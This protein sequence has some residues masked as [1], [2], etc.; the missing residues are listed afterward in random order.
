VPGEHGASGAGGWSPA[1]PASKG[2]LRSLAL[3]RAR[4]RDVHDRAAASRAIQATLIS[5]TWWRQADLLLCYLALPTEVQ[6]AGLLD[7]A[8]ARGLAA[9][10]PRVSGSSMR[11]HAVAAG[12]RDFAGDA[13]GV[14]APRPGAPVIEP[15]AGRSVLVVVPGL[16]FDAWGYRIGRGGGYYDRFL[17][18]LRTSAVTVGL[19]FDDALVDR[20]PRDPWDVPVDIVV[21][22]ARGAMDCRGARQG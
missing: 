17:G 10:A 15:G 16:A 13:L 20:V 6:T 2:E 11:F 14:R 21:T 3:E 5:S 12:E 7:A 19:C 18:A 1:G 9:A 4:L 8:Y 22:E